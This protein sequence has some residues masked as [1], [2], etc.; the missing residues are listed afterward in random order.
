VEDDT[1]PADPRRLLEKQGEAVKDW[2]RAIELCS[3]AQRP[4]FHFSR[5][6]S[7]VRAGQVA[8]GIA[9]VD[10]PRKVGKWTADQCYD[11]ARCNAVASGEATDK[12]REYADRAMKL[13]CEAVK[14]GFRNAANMGKDTD[15]DPLRKRA[16]F[17]KLLE[18][19]AN[20]KAKAPANPKQKP[21][22]WPP[23]H[24]WQRLLSFRTPH[25]PVRTPP[26]PA[27]FRKRS[28]QPEYPRKRSGFARQVG[29]YAVCCHMSQTGNT[30]RRINLFQEVRYVGA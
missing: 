5:A 20:L 21:I 19:L 30:R 17:Q 6:F 11:I 7:R 8:E 18:S 1:L 14:L 4:A 26:R 25:V 23:H 10:E 16:D 12:K 3:P 2:S 9:E 15:L 28:Q 13:L 24:A 22:H 27:P 29:W